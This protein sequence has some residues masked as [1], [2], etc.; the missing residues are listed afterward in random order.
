[1]DFQTDWE[2]LSNATEEEQ[3]AARRFAIESDRMA[4]W[5]LRTI[6]EEEADAERLINIAKEQIAELQD[7]IRDIETYCNHKTAFLK[8]CLREF[9]NGADSA[10]KKD[11]KTQTSYKLLSGSLVMKK[12]T[13]KM[14]QP[15]ADELLSFLRE[16]APEF[17][18]TVES[19]MWGEFKKSLELLDDGS[20]VIEDSG[21]VVPCVEFEDVPE[22]FDIK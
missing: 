22:S 4:E 6:K 7:K 11:T 13:K 17:I 19:P 21:V 14:I 10:Y 5:A 2:A 12:A 16:N 15:S 3:E 9:F 20:V 1:M 8:G 18:K